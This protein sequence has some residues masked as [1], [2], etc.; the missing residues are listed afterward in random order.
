MQMSHNGNIIKRRSSDLLTIKKHCSQILNSLK[1][2]FVYENV[3]QRRLLLKTWEFVL[4][5][6]LINEQHYFF[7]Q[8]SNVSY[9]NYRRSSDLINPSTKI[10]GNLLKTEY[11]HSYCWKKGKANCKCPTTAIPLKT[12]SLNWRLPL[13]KL[14]SKSQKSIVIH[15]GVLTFL[16]L[17]HCTWKCCTTTIIIKTYM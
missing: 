12:F 8:Y 13:K 5:F 3:P 14:F 16:Q 1:L 15:G 2:I 6:L 7:L 11:G 9:G 17:K 10:D 4:T